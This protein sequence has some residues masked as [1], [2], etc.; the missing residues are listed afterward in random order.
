[1]L[2]T[3]PSGYRGCQNR[4][5][6]LARTRGFKRRERLEIISIC[7]KY[8]KIKDTSADYPSYNSAVNF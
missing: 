5:L 1:M 7:I 4:P 6:S 8:T 2:D 3:R